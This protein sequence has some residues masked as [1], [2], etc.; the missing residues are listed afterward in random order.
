MKKFIVNVTEGQKN[1]AG[2]KA[3]KDITRIL[4]D[5]NYQKIEIKIFD[6]KI[7]KLFLTHKEI[8]EVLRPVAAGDLIVVQYPLYSL[9]ELETFLRICKFRR[10]KLVGIVHDVES[11][12]LLKENRVRSIR[13]TAIFNKF[14]CLIVHNEIMK[15]K[16]HQIGV[17]TNMVSLG[18]FDY[19]NDNKMVN[20]GLDKELIFAGNLEKASFMDK[21]TLNLKIKL[22]GINPS[23]KYT[24][25]VTYLGV[26]SP[27]ELPRFL[28]GSFGLVWDGSELITNSGVFGEYT[29]Y[30]NPH[31]VSLYLSCGLPVVVWK[32]AAISAFVKEYQ[33]GLSVDSLEDLPGVLQSISEEEYGTMCR[34]VKK[35]GKMIRDGEFTKRAV[36]MAI[37]SL[38]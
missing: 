38:C 13:E 25:L 24:A 29:R 32:Q 14:D 34:N 4:F 11:L 28:S 37:D 12:R 5:Q 36:D 6:N 22:F 3:K 17:K 26:K 2:D 9:L 16:L 31:K 23:K 33:V 10:I 19:L 21:W 27:D 35:I 20:T 1:T 7:K 15:E 8:K 18:I 30:N